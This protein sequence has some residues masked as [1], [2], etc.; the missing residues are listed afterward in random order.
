MRIE[1]TAVKLFHVSR[2]GKWRLAAL[3]VS[4]GIFAFL[5]GVQ[6]WPDQLHGMRPVN[7]QDELYRYVAQELDEPALCDEIPWSAESPGGFFIAPSYERSNCYAF[8]AGRT[9]N[10][11]FCWQVKRLGAFRLLSQ[12]T[13]MWSCV[14]DARRGMNAGIGVAPENLIRFFTRLGYDADTLHL[15]GI[16]PPLVSVQDFFRQLPGQPDIL[17]R[18]EKS[19]G[20]PR[21]PKS[22][23]HDDATNAA[24]LADIAALVTE[25]P[26]WCTRIPEDLPLVTQRAT[27]RDWCLFTLASN[28]RNAELCRLIPER[29][30]KINPW[31]LLKAQCD[32]QTRSPDPAGRYGPEVPDADD[33]T[34]A[35][36][37]M[38]HYE[39]PH[40][41]DLPPGTVYGAFERFLHELNR[42]TDAPHA[43]AR[44]RRAR[45]R[46]RPRL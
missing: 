42:G 22:F 24:Y 32:F 34:R 6:S 17:M 46:H 15:E 23:A 7:Q 33:R 4:A 10:P 1:S 40:A 9:K 16:T 43:A 31:L 21:R 45:G 26:G 29:A 5:S 27:F 39:I 20:A 3:V 41:K 14:A 36:I 8:I 35:L 25:T 28:T 12:Q 38:L 2:V 19:I 11:W 13:S 37:A 18:I 30:N 44:Q